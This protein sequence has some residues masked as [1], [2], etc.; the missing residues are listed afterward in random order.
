[1]GDRQAKLT[2]NIEKF[3]LEFSSGSDIGKMR[4]ENQDRCDW[5]ETANPGSYIIIVADGMGG[6][7]GGGIAADI[8]LQSIRTMFGI[9]FSDPRKQILK[10]F[11]LA[12]KKLIKRADADVTLCNMGCTI[13]MILFH[14]NKIHAAHIGDS[15]VYKFTVGNV[16]QLS[17]DHSLV[18]EMV[19]QGTI[20]PEDA[21]L[22]PKNNIL[23]RALTTNKDCEIDVY[24]PVK[25]SRNDVYLVC[26][27]GLWNMLE[28]KEIHQIAINNNAET[29][30]K[31]LI[32]R[33]NELGGKDNIAVSIMK[34]IN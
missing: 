11:D 13:S 31:L 18:Q 32:E 15:R 22:H 17:E 1:L 16:N 14:D 28:D 34:V 4:S 7:A 26:S 5:F 8:A 12:S 29:A 25:V 2:K 21:R 24:E 27:D 3:N 23:L 6:P 20:K 9:P 19:K 10:S 30:V 33:A